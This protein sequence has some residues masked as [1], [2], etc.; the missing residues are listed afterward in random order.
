M[1]DAPNVQRRYREGCELTDQR[2]P[3]SYKGS[4]Y[5]T[6]TDSEMHHNSCH[7]NREI[8]TQRTDATNVLIVLPEPM[9]RESDR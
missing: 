3:T 2:S 6:N 5:M 1:A 4:D 9:I 8:C 7:G